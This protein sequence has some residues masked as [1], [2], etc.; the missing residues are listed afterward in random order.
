MTVRELHLYGEPLCR[1]CRAKGRVTEAKHVDHIIPIEQGGTDD[2][3]NLQSLCIS[4]H[5]EKT[6]KDRNYTP[7]GCDANG[8]PTD[9]RHP[10]NR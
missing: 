5:A 7:K 6:A 3:D 1:M 10:W 8:N 4:C 9:P 2:P